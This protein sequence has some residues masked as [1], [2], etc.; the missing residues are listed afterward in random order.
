MA[1]WRAD[2]NRSG[3]LLD[4]E[5]GSSAATRWTQERLLFMLQ[6]GLV[7]AGYYTLTR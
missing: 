6:E 4:G 7:P 5:S 1:L 2:E 3:G